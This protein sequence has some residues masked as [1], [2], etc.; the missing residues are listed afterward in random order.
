MLVGRGEERGGRRE[1]KKTGKKGEEGG[2]EKRKKR[3]EQG[4]AQM[5]V[6][7]SLFSEVLVETCSD[8]RA[9]R[10]KVQSRHTRQHG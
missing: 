6:R 1:K 7:V 10:T 8:E 3:Q 5:Q 9:E 4:A 2:G